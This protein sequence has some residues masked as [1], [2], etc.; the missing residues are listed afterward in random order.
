MGNDGK[1]PFASALQRVK[2]VVYEPLFTGGG[3]Q[4]FLMCLG[5][6]A[7]KADAIPRRVN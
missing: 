7:K 5:Y 1:R 4:Q 3:F 2:R 6:P